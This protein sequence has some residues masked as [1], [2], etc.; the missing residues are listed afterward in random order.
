[1]PCVH[2]LGFEDHVLIAYDIW[3]AMVLFL[4]HKMLNG[5]YKFNYKATIIDASSIV[6]PLSLNIVIFYKKNTQKGIVHDV[7]PSLW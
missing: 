3:L 5:G 7:Q 1:M 4:W 2:L 6:L